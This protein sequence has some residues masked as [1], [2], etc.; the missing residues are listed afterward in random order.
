MAGTYFYAQAHKLDSPLIHL[1]LY[2]ADFFQRDAAGME[3]EGAGLAGKPGWED[4]ALCY[5]SDTA[6]YYGQFIKAT[7]LTRR[8]VE[9]AERVLEKEEA[10]SY[11][12]EAAVR[13]ALVGNLALARQQA[14][15]AAARSNGRDT[16]A[17]SAIALGLAGDSQQAGRL[18][19]GLNK[20]FPKGTMVQSEY[21]PM[22]RAAGFLGGANPSKNAAEAVGALHFA[23][24]SS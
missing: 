19:D 13:E 4:L 15:R 17:I 22:I 10:V 9:S 6:A 18:A 1:N 7:E 2:L 23:P 16:E 5:E 24:E 21:L 14:R 8:A 20:R 12:A 11:D 3:R